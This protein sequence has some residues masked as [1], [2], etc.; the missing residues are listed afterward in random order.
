MRAGRLPWTPCARPGR[1]SQKLADWRRDAPIRPVVFEDAGVLTDDT[2]HLHLEQRMAQRLLAR[3]RA[4]GFVHHDLSRACLVQAADSIPRVLL[5]GR[6]CLFG[7]RAE[8][9]HEVLV[10]V[11]ARWAEPTRR[12]GP[13]RAYAEEAEARTLERLE[14]ALHDAR[15]PGETIHRRLL[16]TA[17]R[18]IEDLLPQLEERAPKRSP[19]ARPPDYANAANARQQQLRETLEAQR[20]R[21]EA[22]LTRHDAAALQLAF[23]FSEDETAPARGRCRL[24][25]HAPRPVRPRPRNRAP[26]HPRVLRD[27]GQAG[28]AHRAGISLARHGVRGTVMR[29]GQLRE[30]RLRDFRCFGE[31]ADRTPRAAHAPR[32]GEQHRQDLVSRCR[33]GSVGCSVWDPLT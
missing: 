20:R 5:L 31:A 13:L 6:L 25:A 3:F 30:I 22:E 10:P 21:V 14:S 2:V 4:Q 11:A 27:P 16:D 8:R 33:A 15:A 19:K 26:P 18:D 17:A 12:D 7:R 23:E 28:G 29:H 9:L 32:R 24:L 1:T